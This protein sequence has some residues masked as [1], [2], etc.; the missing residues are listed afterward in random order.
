MP[1]FK[2]ETNAEFESAETKKALSLLSSKIA[3]ILGKSEDYVMVRIEHSP[4]MSFAGTTE[5]CAFCTLT[6][7]G[8]DAQ[9]IPDLSR[10]LTELVNQTLSVTPERVYVQFDSPERKN[11]AHNGRPFA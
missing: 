7:L 9:K 8:L 5:S 4:T 1:F 2:I 10:T 3:S 6:S 11:F